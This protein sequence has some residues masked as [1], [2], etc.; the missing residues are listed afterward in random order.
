MTQRRELIEDFQRGLFSL[1]ELCRQF[2]VSR[3]TAYKWLERYGEGGEE[4]LADRSRAPRSCPHRTAGQVVAAIVALRQE[5]PRWGPRKL[6]D[7]LEDRRPGGAWPARSTTA[8]ILRRHGLVRPRRRRA[9]LEHPGKPT[10][11]A[12]K[13]NRVWSGDFKG[14]FKTGDGWYCYPL[15]V[16]DSCS[17]YL[18]GCRGLESTAHDLAQPVFRR[19]FAEFG[20]PDAMRT[21]NGTPFATTAIGRLSRLAVW[22]LKLGIRPELIEPAHP[23]QNGSHER[24]HRELK[25]ET[26][27]PPA[28]TLR[29]QQRRFEAFRREFNEERPHESLGGVPPARV[30]R[31]S[32][33]PL[34]QRTP[35]IEYPGHFE[36]RRV[37]RNGGIRWKSDWVNVSHVLSEEDV[38]LEEVADGIWNLYFGLLL[39]GRFDERERRLYGARYQ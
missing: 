29:G 3:K 15:T 5:H 30:Y 38:G 7:W 23:E 14:E 39:L 34:P 10:T 12:S 8:D 26:T 16:V 22:W 35:M 19:L 13:P 11:V 6:L 31:P 2:G 28:A 37:S 27:R 18:L 25:A 21:D 9:A 1:S 4:A 20:L 17:R 33:R 36:V 24:M 32:P